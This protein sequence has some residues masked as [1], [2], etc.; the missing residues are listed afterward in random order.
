MSSKVQMLFEALGDPVSI[1]NLGLLVDRIRD[2]F[3]VAHVA[4]IALSLGRDYV[5]ASRT[6][7]ELS[8][9]AGFWW[10]EAGSLATVSYSPE[11]GA[12]YSE[13]GYARI[14]PVV[15]GASRSFLPINWKSLPWDT[16]KRRQFLMEA[17]ECGLGNQGY[18]VPVRGP[19]GQFALFVVNS[20]ATD[21]EWQNFIETHKSDLLIVAHFFH[22]KVLE[23]EKIFGSP[24]A[25][26]LSS[27]EKDVLTYIALGKSRAQ[28]AYDL[29][30]SENTLRVYL[31]S[32]RHKLCA[33]NIQHAVA[34]GVQ[35]GL[36]NV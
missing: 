19:N 24:P 36:I 3:D 30:I 17:V 1:E 22:Q 5:V 21:S 13:A 23:I 20:T 26:V 28:V 31:D 25:P 2:V 34:I 35:K 9:N 32:A 14:D 27:R 8:N 10:R 29:K 6:V 16:R 12:R 4:Y 15:E 18:T 7:G 11:W 33:L